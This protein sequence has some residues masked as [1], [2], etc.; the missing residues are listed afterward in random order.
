MLKPLAT[1]L[2]ALLVGLP[3]VFVLEEPA[4][5]AGELPEG[6]T[7]S[8]FVSG[9]EDPTM[10]S[11][12]PDGRLFVSEQAGALRVVKN[13]R[14]LPKPFVDLSDKIEVSGARGLLG[15]AF[16]PDFENN[17]FVYVYYTRKATNKKP[18]RNRIVR[19][20]ADGNVAARGSKRTIF[21]LDDL[22]KHHNHNGGSMNF[23]EDGK[24]YV[25]VGDNNRSANAQ[26]LRNLKGKMLRIGKNGEIPPNNPFYETAKGKNRA[27]WALGFRNP[28]S[29]AIQ[30]GTGRMF[31]ND[32][33]EH[34]WEEI[35]EGKE[36]ANYGWPRYEGPEESDP[37]YEGPIFAYEHEGP[38]GTT[39]CAIT[40][41]AFYNPETVKFPAEY[42]G[43]YYFADYCNGW[44]R[45][46]DPESGTASDFKASSDQAPVDLKVGDD[47]DLY[48]LSRNGSVQ[49]IRYTN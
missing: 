14:L 26:T 20:T 33:G 39:G 46:L 12:A 32:V 34:R 5:G 27:I 49:R 7:Q 11:F 18:P 6:F 17:G 13:G 21:E 38:A 16:D 43:H 23:G 48:F 31:I 42:T 1:I 35:D 47:G 36:G 37:S 8:R 25:S 2:L 30:P 40:G 29:F 3:F 10:M 45:R 19:F 9:L 41:G 28:Y 15:I 24:L 22:S 4:A 44:I